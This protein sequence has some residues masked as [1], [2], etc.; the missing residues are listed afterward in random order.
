MHICADAQARELSVS[1]E[2][3]RFPSC[4]SL[5]LP[6]ELRLSTTVIPNS[7]AELPCISLLSVVGCPVSFQNDSNRFLKWP[8]PFK[9]DAAQLASNANKN[10]TGRKQHILPRDG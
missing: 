1:T 6:P 5:T 9:R 7:L 4:V 10:E 8:Q 3:H 2:V